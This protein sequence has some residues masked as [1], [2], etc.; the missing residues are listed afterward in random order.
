MQEISNVIRIPPTFQD[1]KAK[2]ITSGTKQVFF[3]V[4]FLNCIS[5]QNCLLALSNRYVKMLA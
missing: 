5:V 4:F 2:L 1:P 3:I